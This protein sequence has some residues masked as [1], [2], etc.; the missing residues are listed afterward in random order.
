MGY[1]ILKN[2]ILSNKLEKEVLFMSVEMSDVQRILN[3]FSETASLIKNQADTILQ[4]IS[5]GLSP[6]Q[7]DVVGF[8]NNILTLQQT[9]ESIKLLANQYI[10]S[11]STDCNETTIYEYASLIEQQ[12]KVIKDQ[13]NAARKVLQRFISVKSYIE[14]YQ[15][16]LAP[17]QSEASL[18]L[19]ELDQGYLENINGTVFSQ[20]EMFLCALDH[21]DLMDDIGSELLD[22][23]D[24]C[25]PSD[26][27]Y[28]LIR[29]K[30]YIE[31]LT[32][33]NSDDGEP[34]IQSSVLPPL[35]KKDT[36]TGNNETKEAISSDGVSLTTTEEPLQ[37]YT[38]PERDMIV[39]SIIQ[40]NDQDAFPISEFSQKVIAQNLL[41]PSDFCF[42]ELRHHQGT[43]KNKKISYIRAYVCF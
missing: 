39:D 10:S 11:E 5:I 30:Y 7:S 32:E 6:Q 13:V 37:S 41:V 15:A 17:Y 21:N 22:K 20:S 28:G 2:I 16:A 18:L 9:Y 40:N 36:L 3:H 33:G 38:E 24:A 8:N 25:Y 23:L 12:R 31:K 4:N 29:K 34:R 35:S 42:G 27:T 1:D 43:G 26:V 14:K 19:N